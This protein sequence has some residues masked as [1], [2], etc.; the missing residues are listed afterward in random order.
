MGDYLY[1]EGKPRGWF[2]ITIVVLFILVPLLTQFCLPFLD[3]VHKVS[4]HGET[5]VGYWGNILAS[6]VGTIGAF[7]VSVYYVKKVNE[8]K[9]DKFS[10][11][12]S[13][14][15]KTLV[16]INT[17]NVNSRRRD[18]IHEYFYRL[19]ELRYLVVY[20]ADSRRIEQKN[21]ELSNSFQDIKKNDFDLSNFNFTIDILSLVNQ[22]LN[23]RNENGQ[24][25][26]QIRDAIDASV[27]KILDEL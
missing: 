16:E 12:I 24:L 3:M 1:K 15:Q 4:H 19:I 8:N 11:S 22:Y 18:I 2:V 7:M 13:N 17:N 23:Q 10:D 9:E 21:N 26:S 25:T 5:W 27:G 20:G 6:A 14:L